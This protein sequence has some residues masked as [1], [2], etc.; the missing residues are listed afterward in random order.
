MRGASILWTEDVK[1][2]VRREEMNLIVPVSLMPEMTIERLRAMTPREL[3]D[4]EQSHEVRSEIGPFG[5]PVAVLIPIAHYCAMLELAD[6]LDAK[7]KL[8]YRTWL[9]G[10]QPQ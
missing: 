4:L 6:K 3:K 9:D 10:V 2:I 5:V 7:I 1:A 8:L